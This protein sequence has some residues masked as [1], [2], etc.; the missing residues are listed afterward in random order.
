MF[1]YQR[2]KNKNRFWW[3]SLTTAF[4]LYNALVSR[5]WSDF[6]MTYNYAAFGPAPVSLFNRQMPG[7]LG[8]YF[9][10]PDYYWNNDVF[11]VVAFGF[12][13]SSASPFDPSFFTLSTDSRGGLQYRRATDHSQVNQV[14]YSLGGP[15][16]VAMAMQ[17]NLTLGGNLPY[18]VYPHMVVRTAPS[19]GP[20]WPDTT[21]YAPPANATDIN[22]ATGALSNADYYSPAAWVSHDNAPLT[23]VNAGA[24]AQ[25]P[26]QLWV[27]M[28]LMPANTALD[29]SSCNCNNYTGTAMEVTTALGVQ[30][31]PNTP[32]GLSGPTYTPTN[33]AVAP[34]GLMWVMAS[35]WTQEFLGYDIR[36]PLIF[37]SRETGMG[38]FY[39][40][41]G[42]QG[43][44]DGTYAGSNQAA[45]LSLGTPYQFLSPTGADATDA[46]TGF[47]DLWT[48]SIFTPYAA[49]NSAPGNYGID[50]QT[51]IFCNDLS[52]RY[53]G[54]YG[55]S[56]SM[57][58]LQ[59]AAASADPYLLLK[60]VALGYNQG[61]HNGSILAMECGTS[62]RA[63]A[64]TSTNVS[65][66]NGIVGA[67]T[68][69]P[70]VTDLE[71]R[72]GRTNTVYDW[73][74]TWGDVLCFLG[75]LQT[76]NF[77]N[78]APSA[79]NWTAMTNELQTA[80][81]AM[82]GKSPNT[83]S[84]GT[85]VGPNRISFR[86]NWLTMLRIMKKYIP[87]PREYLSKGNDFN[88]VEFLS[89]YNSSENG[90]STEETNSLCNPVHAAPEIYWRA[91]AYSVVPTTPFQAITVTNCDLF[92]PNADV[93]YYND[94]NT[95]LTVR[96]L[97]SAA[98][99]QPGNESFN[100]SM[101]KDG[102][103]T[104]AILADNT[105]Q[106]IDWTNIAA[107]GAGTVAGSTNYSSTVPVA[108]VTG[109]RRLY[110]DANDADGYRTIGWVDVYFITCTPTPTP[111]AAFT[112]TFTNTVTKTNTL[113]PT[114]TQTMTNTFTPTLSNTFTN[115]A[116]ET[117][118][119]TFTN[120]LT[121][122]ATVSN[123]YTSTP[124]N[125]ATKTFT[126]TFTSTPVNTNT[127]SSTPT[128]TFTST[129][130]S[131]FTNTPI[132]TSTF[133]FTPTVTWTNTT[134]P[135][136]I[137]TY[138]DTSTP[139]ATATYTDTPVITSTYTDTPSATFTNTN[140]VTPINTATSTSTLVLTATYTD[141]P[142][143][144]PTATYSSTPVFTFTNTNTPI[145][146]DTYTNSPT[147]TLTYTYT[148]T[149]NVAFTST[150]T[151]TPTATQTT[152][153]T[154]TITATTTA[155]RTNTPINTYTPTATP[156]SG[157]FFISKNVFTPND[158]VQIHVGIQQVPGHY[159]LTIY[160]SAGEHIKT[161]DSQ[162]LT[163]PFQKT[164]SWNGKN[165]FGDTCSSG[166]YVVYLT[167]PFKR[168]LGR[169]IFIH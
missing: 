165:K 147:A 72:I 160:N 143:N 84:D 70:E 101:W 131:T 138:T 20:T 127:S 80:F 139:N 44:P 81:N 23:V 12:D 102:Y 8:D 134:S 50:T 109:L 49:N 100:A 47:P 43:F 118:T 73:G 122:T 124:S 98:N 35:A 135:T 146:T 46:I 91:P 41:D 31:M 111:N 141:T 108:G 116:T 86:Y 1:C 62:G 130:S 88:D 48:H 4:F 114:N 19:W 25:H 164:Y 123:T 125:T 33:G 14:P 79:A 69:A 66:T 39:E 52:T 132:L 110:M 89:G 9:S 71:R 15:A 6:D 96:W 136:P 158:Q 55:A 149:S 5:A 148:P 18:P 157:E 106:T 107:G 16:S 119:S 56:R 99:P 97:M 156:I 75:D 7:G 37:G 61:P 90:F 166:V 128:S 167:E 87:Q 58:I 21:L 68:Y 59:L 169:V 36:V 11:E 145:A 133:T 54:Y 103:Q 64:I 140:S 85:T 112:A 153:N 151:N 30:F 83:L 51:I 78:G 93:K 163:S 154:A 92:T 2:G 159:D 161:L 38:L 162:T 42:A 24:L 82:K 13:S 142:S 129:L 117:Y 150:W 26:T 115:T 126:Q 94:D 95:T 137:F 45:V 105:T 34:G 22:A 27:G 152:T 65:I 63:T 3:Q 113:T 121:N 168:L 144:S 40:G 17:F 29:D 10:N 77:G 32:T 104:G 120:T 155:T 67:N 53:Y 74:I 57:K 28:P 60:T 76:N